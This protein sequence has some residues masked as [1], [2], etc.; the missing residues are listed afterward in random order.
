MS[1][2]ARGRRFRL[3]R[4]RASPFRQ[5]AIATARTKLQDHSAHDTEQHL[6]F[7]QVTGC[8]IHAEGSRDVGGEVD[9]HG[10][11]AVGSLIHSKI[12][13]LPAEASLS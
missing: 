9:V 7:M 13:A 4:D 2:I 6:L 12:M 3:G 11:K 10:S 1:N 5:R 8:R